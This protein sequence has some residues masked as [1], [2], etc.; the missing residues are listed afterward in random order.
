MNEAR[1]LELYRKIAAIERRI[2]KLEDGYHELDNVVD[3]EGWIGEA[4]KL[5]TE[6]VEKVET[7]IEE[8]NKKIDIILQHITGTKGD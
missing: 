6:D 7:K 1:I 5:L 2:A 4:F 3:P 8:V